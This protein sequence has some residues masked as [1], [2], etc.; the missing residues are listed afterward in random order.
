MKTARNNDDLHSLEQIIEK[1][2]KKRFWTMLGF[3]LKKV[4]YGF[5]KILQRLV[6]FCLSLPCALLAILTGLS[7]LIRKIFTGKKIFKKQEIF[8]RDAL[9]L[10]LYKFNS[11]S[12]WIFILPLFMYAIL[13]KL[14]LIGVGIRNYDDRARVIGDSFLFNNK[15]GIFSL[16]FIRES[17][18]TTYQDK[19]TTDRE[20]ITKSR[21]I[22]DLLI[23]L[24]YIPA[25][26]YSEK[27]QSYARYLN[28]FD[29]KI[30]NIDVEEALN[31]ISKTI[32]KNDKKKLFFV[33]PAC[34]NT[35]LQ[36]QDYR[37][38]LL[39]KTDYIFADGIG[40]VVASKILNTPLKA[41]INGTDLL[42]FICKLAIEKD[43]NLYFLG[44]KP[45]IVEQAKDNLEQKYQG[46]KI[47]GTQHGYFDR[48]TENEQ[49]I[50]DINQKQPDIL[51]TAFGV[52]NQE[53]WINNNF[54]KFDFPGVFMGV[55]GLFDFY[56]ETK[57]R[58]PRW[59]RQIGMEWLFRLLI[60]PRR[61]WKRYIIGNPYFI[62]QVLRYKYLGPVFQEEI[63]EG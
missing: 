34:L 42:P 12:R 25:L 41:N 11:S 2:G 4:V 16:W 9:K 57:Q 50:A 48:K 55:G 31:I 1:G 47:V 43:Y 61:M 7:F 13:G 5:L 21:P 19:I 33:N 28:I 62:A 8:G 3:R 53:K 58:A 39:N 49:I 44:A 59:M 37:N 63:Q 52:P 51:L 20:Y 15:P 38:I 29:V 36:D 22:K 18:R 56:S 26:F 23:L 24:Q 6:S 40:I 17:S 27:R 46:L 30:L 60:E 10:T 54:D 45:G 35:S 32:Q 14:Q